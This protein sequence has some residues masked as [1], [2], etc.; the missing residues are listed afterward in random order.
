M[1]AGI[2][3]EVGCPSGVRF[4]VFWGHESYNKLH[5]PE[6]APVFDET[7]EVARFRFRPEIATQL[8]AG[9]SLAVEVRTENPAYGAGWEFA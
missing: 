7:Q 9:L 1:Y 6:V 5:Q 2:S 3:L 4:H 8:V